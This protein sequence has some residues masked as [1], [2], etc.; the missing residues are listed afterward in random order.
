MVCLIAALVPA[1]VVGL[2]FMSAT[3]TDAYSAGGDVWGWPVVA[4]GE[5]P[6]GWISLGEQP[7]GVVAIGYRAVGVIAIGPFAIGVVAIGPVAAGA[8]SLSALSLGLWSIGAVSL[9]WVALGPFAAGRFA[10]GPVAVGWYAC[11]AR[12][13]GVYAWGVVTAWGFKRA[14]IIA[15]RSFGPPQK[16]RNCYSRIGGG[17]TPLDRK[18]AQCPRPNQPAK[19]AMRIGSRLVLR[20]RTPMAVATAAKPMASASQNP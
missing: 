12:A 13:I 3:F 19:R 15:P 14:E 1:M 17:L 9:G 20:S 11:G 5:V 8:I 4:R 6:R 2:G 10:L 7:V 18:Q 16:P